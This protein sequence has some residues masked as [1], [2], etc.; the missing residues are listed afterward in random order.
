M[1]EGLELQVV[2]TAQT[3]Q[4]QDRLLTIEPSLQSL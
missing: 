1:P 4:D 3:Q 2:V